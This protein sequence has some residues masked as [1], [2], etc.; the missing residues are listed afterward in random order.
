MEVCFKKPLLWW[1]A[2]H[3]CYLSAWVTQ[4]QR[5][6]MH[7]LCLCLSLVWHKYRQTVWH[8]DPFSAVTGTY[9][10]QHVR[11]LSVILHPTSVFVPQSLLYISTLWLHAWKRQNKSWLFALQMHDVRAGAGISV[12][13]FVDLLIVLNEL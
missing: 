3:F 2:L 9:G 1:E 13:Y 6:I 11:S 7:F 10:A 12:S 4:W 5:P 8:K